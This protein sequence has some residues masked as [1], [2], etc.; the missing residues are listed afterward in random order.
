M[1]QCFS[2]FLMIFNKFIVVHHFSSLQI[3]IIVKIF[4]VFFMVRNSHQFSWLFIKF[5]DCHRLS[6][7][8]MS[9]PPPPHPHFLFFDFRIWLRSTTPATFFLTAIF[10][11]PQFLFDTLLFIHQVFKKIMSFQPLVFLDPRIWLRSTVP[12]FCFFMT[13]CGARG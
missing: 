3:F 9:S 12:L 1:F 5:P 2:S 6:S 7:V 4:I 11:D 8:F 13:L 10:V